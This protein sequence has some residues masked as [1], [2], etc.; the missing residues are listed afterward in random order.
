[1]TLNFAADQ[2]PR[3]L[4]CYATGQGLMHMH[5]QA[6]TVTIRPKRAVQVG[7]TKY[8][9]TAPTEQAGAYYWWSYLVMRPH[10][11]DRW[12]SW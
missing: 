1:M 10:A 6:N 5:W 11:E 2:L 3:Q 4:R 12:Y 7:R 9:C 8:N